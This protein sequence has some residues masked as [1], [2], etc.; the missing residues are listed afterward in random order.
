MIAFALILLV[1]QDCFPD[2]TR[3]EVVF[4]FIFSQ[5]ATHVLV[6]I[7]EVLV[8]FVSSRGT[9]NNDRPRRFLPY[10]LC[11]RAILY[12]LEILNIVFGGYV[13]WSPYIQDHIR[14]EHSDRASYTI[15]AYEIS[16]I[17]VH[18]IIAVLFM[19]YFDPL[20]LKTPS[21]LKELD[22]VGDND[23]DD[24]IMFELVKVHH[25]KQGGKVHKVVE[26]KRMYRASART[27]WTQRVRV[28]C[29][30]AGANNRAKR[31]A[32][33][34]IA[35]AMATIFDG[36]EMVTTDFIA[37]LMLVHRDQKEQIKK[38]RDLGAQLKRVSYPCTLHGCV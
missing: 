24:D 25:N 21:L 35:H 13:A 27:R 16:L 3:E 9:I 17:V 18:V 6:I 38:Q 2:G 19:I 28:L 4:T 10:F 36:V 26:R 7:S 34:D 14:C 32:L 23:N 5:I 15:A 33:E 29:C 31:Q 22:I 30:C 1:G 20:G 11:I 12:A 37:A 8:A